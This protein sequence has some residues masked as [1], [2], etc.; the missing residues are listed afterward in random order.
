MK[1][2]EA[3]AEGTQTVQRRQGWFKHSLD[4]KRERTDPGEVNPEGMRNQREAETH[5]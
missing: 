4:V 5:L 1:G 2:R 3:G